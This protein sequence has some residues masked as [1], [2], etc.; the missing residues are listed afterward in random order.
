LRAN[1]AVAEAVIGNDLVRACAEAIDRKFLS[2][3][4]ISDASPPAILSGISAIS[5]NSDIA[6]SL[7]ALLESLGGS[8]ERAVFVARAATYASMMSAN[9]PRIGIPDGV[10]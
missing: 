9:F 7:R 10:C 2:D 1:S 4:A 5:G 6:Y 3:E 8:L